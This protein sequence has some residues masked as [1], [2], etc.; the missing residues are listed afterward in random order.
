MDLHHPVM[1][2]LETMLKSRNPYLEEVVDRISPLETSME[3][4]NE[5]K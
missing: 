4:E 5:I 1:P 2:L 3:G